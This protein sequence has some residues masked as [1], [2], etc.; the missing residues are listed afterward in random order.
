MK[1]EITATPRDQHGTGVSRRMRLAGSVPGVV[2]GGSK[3]VAAIQLDH[4]GIYHQLKQ[5]AFHASILTLEVSGAKEQVL[6]RDVQMHPFKPLV[7]HVDFQRVSA[8][9][10]IHMKIPLHF[11]NADVAPGVKLSGGIVSH[12]MNEVEVKCLAKDL[13]EYFEV[14]L[15]HL[16]TGHSIHL[17]ELKIPE[18]VE[19]LELQHGDLPIAT[20]VIPRGHIE[21]A[22]AAVAEVAPEAEGAAA[23]ATPAKAAPTS[24]S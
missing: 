3:D 18:N 20:V 11:I 5:E 15:S 7:L 24:K 4:N 10:K 12:I 1:F 17:S 2:Y 6:L 16:E 8:T 22:A 19:L 9:E 14:D 23:P 21:E 13:P